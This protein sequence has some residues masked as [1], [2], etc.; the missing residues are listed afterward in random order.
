MIVTATQIKIKGVIA[1]LRFVPR[2]Y[3]IQ[4]QLNNIDGLVFMKFSGLSTLTGWESHEAMKNFRNSGQHF[5]A[6]KNVK[7]VGQTKSITW[8]TKSEPSWQEARQKL[9]EVTF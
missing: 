7:H 6:I 2:V 9:R 8:E 3:A 1:F 5:D 4:K